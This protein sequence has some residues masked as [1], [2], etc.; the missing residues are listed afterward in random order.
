ML[1]VGPPS[2]GSELQQPVEDHQRVAQRAGH[3]DR[4]QAG[5]LVGHV[6]QPGH[7]A[8]A[9]EVPRVGSGVDRGDRDLEAHPIDGRDVPVA[10]ALDEWDGLV[11]G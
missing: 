10:E 6:V 9:S 11:D 1:S 5:E 7:T 8:A 4:V 3:D 2:P